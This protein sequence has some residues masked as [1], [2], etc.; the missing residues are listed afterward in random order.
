MAVRGDWME[1]SGDRKKVCK[2][3]WRSCGSVG[4]LVEVFGDLWKCVEI[5][6]KCV[7][8]L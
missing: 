8:I 7:E 5:G 2:G 6:R 1:V 3:E 4:D